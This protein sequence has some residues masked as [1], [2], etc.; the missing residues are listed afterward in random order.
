[1][2]KSIILFM[3]LLV[4]GFSVKATTSTKSFYRDYEHNFTF[5]EH[6][7]TFAVFRNG[8]FDFY[9]NRPHRGFNF[10][11]SNNNVN[12]SF[13]SGY[14]Y[15]AFVQYDDF[16]AVIQVE[17]V[18][19]YYDYYGR[20]K[21]IGS[22]FIN[23]RYGNIVQIGGLHVYYN[24]YGY[25]THFTGY[26]N[27]Y[28]RSYVH[29]PYYR[30]FTRPWFDYRIV[31]YKPYRHHYKAKRY[32]YKR[33][34]HHHYYNNNRNFYHKRN[35]NRVGK[36]FKT[37]RVP[38]RMNERIAKTRRPVNYNRSNTVKRS[39]HISH[40]KNNGEIIRRSHT[41]TYKNRRPIVEKNTKVVVRKKN[42]VRKPFQKHEIK[43]RNTVK[44]TQN[45]PIS[46]VNKYKKSLR[47]GKKAGTIRKRRS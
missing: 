23:Y 18:P 1:M 32:A 29:R 22:V 15:D 28:N 20:V 13:N 46:S 30:F 38:K 6:G 34:N 47:T 39:S 10:G 33:N 42:P 21:R 5:V 9:I 11:Y 37:N 31:S 16:G 4:T 40:N 36:R 43:R 24:R 45:S 19:I 35:T 7:I 41:T 25:Y 3:A 2:K 44:R 14:N 27:R 17:D 8:E 26:I 12:I